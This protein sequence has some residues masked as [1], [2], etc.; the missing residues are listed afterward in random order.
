MRNSNE[1]E[2]IQH[3][4]NNLDID[5]PEARTLYFQHDCN[6]LD[7][8][9]AVLRNRNNSPPQPQANEEEAQEETPENDTELLENLP[10]IEQPETPENEQV[11]VVTAHFHLTTAN[12]NF[13]RPTLP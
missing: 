2:D 13:I 1:L 6:R 10:P 8:V 9:R 3:I 11:L 4:M 7:A 12:L 5:Y